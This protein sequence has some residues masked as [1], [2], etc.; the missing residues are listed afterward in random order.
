MPDLEEAAKEAFQCPA[1]GTIEN[2]N[3]TIEPELSR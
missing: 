1:I 3:V 2:K